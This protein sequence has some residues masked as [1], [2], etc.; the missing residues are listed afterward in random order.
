[1]ENNIS[2]I[3]NKL[4]MK[5]VSSLGNFFGLILGPISG[6]LFV[7]F[8]VDYD[9]LFPLVWGIPVAFA[10]SG[11]V[12]G[13]LAD[14]EGYKFLS[15]ITAIVGILATIIVGWIELDI[16]GAG[17]GLI[18]GLLSLLPLFIGGVIGKNIKQSTYGKEVITS[19]KISPVSM[20]NEH[21][22]EQQFSTKESL[23]PKASSP[24]D[25]DSNFCTNCGFETSSSYRFC[26][27]CGT[28]IKNNKNRN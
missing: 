11:F 15:R 1:M 21:R 2:Q 28:T 7:F 10:I 22:T 13:L 12:L 25:F 3:T 19:S 6:F 20:L 27:S 26:T 8:V 4:G 5:K 16:L 14:M 9:D 24:D 18:L 23:S 17:I